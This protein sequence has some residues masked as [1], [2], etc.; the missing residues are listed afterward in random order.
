MICGMALPFALFPSTSA[1][2]YSSLD[3]ESRP[4]PALGNPI[5]MVITAPTLVPLSS[6]LVGGHY[7]HRDCRI[8]TSL[9]VD[10]SLCLYSTI[11]LHKAISE[12]SF[13]IK[14]R[15]FKYLL[16]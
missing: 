3:L 8:N 4:G 2:I 13:L 7:H 16:A 9:Q 5:P 14:C 1:W 12:L 11:C 10:R 6:S 15:R